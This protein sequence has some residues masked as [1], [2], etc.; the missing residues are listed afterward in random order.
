MFCKCLSSQPAMALG[1]Q[2]CECLSPSSSMHTLSSQM[3]SSWPLTAGTVPGTSRGHHLTVTSWALGQ[4]LL[5][6]QPREE[7]RLS[8]VPGILAKWS[9]GPA[10]Q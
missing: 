7:W 9:P 1:F 10:T 3:P 8:F 4:S 2:L 5:T 6:H